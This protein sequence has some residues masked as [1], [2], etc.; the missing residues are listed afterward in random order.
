[1]RVC[2]ITQT[3]C[4]PRRALSC[5]AL[6]FVAIASVEK[7][8]GSGDHHPHAGRQARAGVQSFGKSHFSQI[9]IELDWLRS[10]Q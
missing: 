3:I 1:M 10:S 2:Q 9:R 6:G 5:R 7:P 8:N 4:E